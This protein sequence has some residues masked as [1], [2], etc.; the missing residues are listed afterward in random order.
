MLGED[1]RRTLAVAARPLRH[2]YRGPSE[3]GHLFAQALLQAVPGAD[4]ALINAGAV[5]SDLPA[6]PIT[7]GDLYTSFPFD[8]RVATVRLTGRQ[9]GRLI[10]LMLDNSS[11][12][13]QLAGARLKLRCG[14]SSNELLSAVTD[15][16]QQP[17]VP[18]RSY[19]VV[20]ND[21]L[22]TGGGGLGELLDKVPPERKRV[23][24][25]R[26]VREEIARYLLTHK[27]PLNSAENPVRSPET[28]PITFESGP[29]ERQ[30]ERAQHLCR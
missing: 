26:H 3:L 22:L 13:L 4:I 29:C 28:P 24:E 12:L 8:N 5:R 25:K 11:G 18:E 19:T 20:I 27:V 7:L 21:F 17:L 10:Q 2:R 15:L 14:P 23:H 1:G 6:G 16:K 9:V 30:Q